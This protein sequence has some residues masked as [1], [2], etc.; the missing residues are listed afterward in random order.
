MFPN[1]SQTWSLN[2]TQTFSQ[3]YSQQHSKLEWKQPIK[4][5]NIILMELIKTHM[6]NKKKEKPTMSKKI[7]DN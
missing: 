3:L 6:S 7:A 4:I 2:V 1:F 5:V